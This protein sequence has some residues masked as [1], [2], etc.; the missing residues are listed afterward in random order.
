MC[1]DV[2]RGRVVIDLSRCGSRQL[3]D[4]YQA[5]GMLCARGKVRAALLKASGESVDA[6]YAL[7]DVLVTV[8]RVAGVPLRFKLALVAGSE[9]LERMYRSLQPELRSLGCES[10]VFRA[11]REAVRWLGS[12]KRAAQAPVAAEAS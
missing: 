2:E 11:E 9:P 10:R 6:H 5:F 3:S 8:G 12:G 1:I 4:T 7:R